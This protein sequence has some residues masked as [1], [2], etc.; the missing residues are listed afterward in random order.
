[1]LDLQCMNPIKEAGGVASPSNAAKEVIAVCNFIS[2]YKGG[3]GAVRDLIEYIIDTNNYTLQDNEILKYR[4]D[5]AVAIIS[6]LDFTRL[7]VGRYDVNDFF[8]IQF[9]IIIR[10]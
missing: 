2:Q 3:E 9:N 5:T 4:I 10:S 1:M 6:K 8:I 7:K